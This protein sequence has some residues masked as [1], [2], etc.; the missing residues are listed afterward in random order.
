MLNLLKNI[1]RSIRKY[2]LLTAT[3]ILLLV[4]LGMNTLSQDIQPSINRII[5]IPNIVLWA[6]ERPE[7]LEFINPDEIG[8]AFLARTIYLRGDR[9][10]IR[11]RLQP[12]TVP[13]GTKLI[14][15]VRIE[16]DLSVPP[17]LSSEQKTKI[18]SEIISLIHISNVFTIQIDF[19]A[20][21]SERDFYRKI[22]T[23]LRNS[24]P[25]SV[26]LSITALASWCIYDTWISD[27]PI[28]EA[29]PM[30]FRM[31]ADRKQIIMYLESGGDFRPSVCKHSL[32]ISTNE[33]I[34]KLPSDRRIYIFNPR[35]W[36]KTAFDKIISE[37]K[38][39]N[40]YLR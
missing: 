27:L 34:S 25:D 29:V 31:G 18:V 7:D 16:S 30:L 23:D 37:V 5:E 6:W 12:L 28:D 35:S 3:I 36:S 9:V 38:N 1:N 32:G 10:I 13:D 21:V 14:A 11:P 17:F 22:I 19:D 26:G 40:I 33:P 2:N 24:L 15:V 4:I 20:K 8:V 39:E